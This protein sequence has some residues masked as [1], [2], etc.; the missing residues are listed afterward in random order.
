MNLIAVYGIV[1]IIIS[2]VGL[3]L[4][5]FFTEKNKRKKLQITNNNITL[6]ELFTLY[7]FN[8]SLQMD[9]LN[10]FVVAIDVNGFNDVLADLRN[11]AIAVQ[12]ASDK[13]RQREAYLKF[14]G[15]Y[16]QTNEKMNR[17][18]RV[19]PGIVE[20]LKIGFTIALLIGLMLVFVPLV[21]FQL[22]QFGTDFTFI[23]D[24]AGI[25]TVSLAGL[26][27]ISMIVY[28]IQIKAIHI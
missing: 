23:L 13:I 28:A 26:A 6:R 27:F 25:F 24:R 18:L 19:K 2:S 20:Y 3:M 12:N 4:L 10:R 15:M 21:G 8:A 22:F 17:A 14:V 16:Y 9:K 7:R 11:Q 5:M 1:T